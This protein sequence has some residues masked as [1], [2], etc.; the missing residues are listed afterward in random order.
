MQH[1]AQP[2]GRATHL[3]ARQHEARHKGLLVYQV[4]DERQ[5]CMRAG[6]VRLLHVHVL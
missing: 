1:Q 2:Q 5:A 3:W 4:V 6:Q